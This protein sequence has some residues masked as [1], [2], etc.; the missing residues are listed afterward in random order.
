MKQCSGRFVIRMPG[1]LHLRLKEE[2]MHA[3][4]SLNQWCVARLKAREQASAWSGAQ[5]GPISSPFLEKIVQRW[6][7]DLDGLVLFGSAARG[8]A[9]EDS[10]IDMLLIMTRRVKIARTLYGDW[11][12]FCRQHAGTQD[13]CRVSPHFVALPASVPEAGGLWYETALDGIVLW[14]RDEGVSR[15]LRSVRVAMAEG[16][17][18]RRVVHGSPYWVKKF[19]KIDA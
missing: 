19:E 8:D 12:E 1:S 9:T 7:E 17:I 6:G 4:Q 3:A 2:A 11:E 15:F 10:D 18:R 13:P 5:D 16:S 14:Q